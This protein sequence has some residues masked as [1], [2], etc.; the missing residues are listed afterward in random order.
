MKIL[1]LLCRAFGLFVGVI[2]GSFFFMQAKQMRLRSV[3]GLADGLGQLNG[4]FFVIL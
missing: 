2:A 1:D 4:P 3:R